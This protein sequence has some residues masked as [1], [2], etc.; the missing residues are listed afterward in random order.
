M[1]S[2]DESKNIR[3]ALEIIKNYKNTDRSWLYVFSNEIEGEALLS[4]IQ[5]GYLKV[6]RVSDVRTLIFMLLQTK[7]ELLFKEAVK[8]ESLNKRLIEAVVVG[9][10]KS[11]KEMIKALS[12]FGQM[13]GYRVEITAFDKKKDIKS[14]LSAECPELLDEEH[15]N[16]F[17]DDG[18]AQYKIDIKGNVDVETAE[19]F[20]EI[21][22]IKNITYI[23]VDIGSD[24]QNIRISIKLRHFLK[25]YNMSPRIQAVVNDTERKNA[26]EGIK[27]YSEQAF[28]IDY[29]GDVKSLYAVGSIIE[30]DLE[31]DALKRHL[32]WGKET[33]F[34]RYEYNYRSS[35]ASALHRKMKIKCNV[36]GITKLPEERS[37]NEKLVLRMMEHRRWNAYMRTEG[38]TYA[39]N[40]NNIAK[41]HNCLV[42]YNK[43]SPK[44]KAKDD[45]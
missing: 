5:S 41:T 16:Q 4:S 39:E 18:E 37:E 11:G 42:T 3:Q 32:K 23:F 7:G 17:D 30:S 44:D 45:D 35:L 9:A 10:G 13:D 33:D 38:Y 14:R 19:F 1:M 15:N 40:R 21:K 25:K 6:R 24:E 28:D 26:L 8:I 31:A 34:W 20:E 27:N 22:R 2:D 29:V 36:P 43:L 12:W